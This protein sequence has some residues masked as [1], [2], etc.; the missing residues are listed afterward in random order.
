MQPRRESPSVRI[1]PEDVANKIAAGEV[2]ERPASVVKELLENALDAGATRISVRLVGAGRRLIEV[3]DNGCGMSEQNALLA[4]ERHATSKVRKAE[5]LDAIRTMGFRGEA[6]PS[7]AAV[8]QFELV[9]RRAKD[10]AASRLRIDGGILRDVEQVGA[11]PGTRVTV[12]RLYFNTP[13]RAKFLKGVTTELS[14]CIDAVQRHALSHEGIGFQLFHND[15][16]LLDVPEHATLRERVALI[17]GLSFAR[18]MVEL[19][20]EQAGIK[21]RGLIGQP[22]LT[23]SGRSHQFF[24]LNSRPVVNR[25]LQYGL[26]DGYRGLITVGRYPVGVILLDMHPRFVDVNIHPAKREVRFRDERAARDAVRDVV[27]KRLGALEPAKEPAAVATPSAPQRDFIAEMETPEPE[28]PALRAETRPEARL[29]TAPPPSWQPQPETPPTRPADEWDTP[30]ATIDTRD[31]FGAPAPEPEAAPA[32]ERQA[33]RDWAGD[34]Q[35]DL[36]IER[37]I[38]E[39]APDAVYRPMGAIDE[40]PLQLFDTYLLVPGTDRLLIID[41]HALHERLNYDALVNELRDNEYQSQ[42]LA[43]PLVFEVAP[44]QVRLLETNLDIFR[45]VGIEIES[46]G[47]NSFQVTAVCH[48]YEEREVTDLIYKMLDEMAQGDLFTKEDILADMLRLATRACKASVRAGDRL[49]PQERKA[50]L[51]GFRRLRPPYTCP[52]GRPIITELT[53]RQM[54]KSFRRIQ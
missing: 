52:H 21:V 47:G 26:E 39:V 38:G 29:Q 48:L 42:Q 53:Q 28:A 51:D 44:S 4:I 41:Q 22:G 9:T 1:L 8:S 11:P 34:E 50:L 13:V 3:I 35:P 31:T 7:I 6:L 2:V 43:V 17:W 32:E 36:P 25:S 46:F 23:R 12:N 20:G 27:R 40:A 30:P 5:D 19:R 54:E 49:T 14:H 15:K 16:L 18:E 24:F 10:E 33:L 37:E 45:K